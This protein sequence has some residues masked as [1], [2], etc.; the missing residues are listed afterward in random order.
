MVRLLDNNFI[1]IH[2]PK[3][4]GTASESGSDVFEVK[5]FD[6]NAYLAQS[7][8][9]YKQMAMASGF[10]R[11][12]EVG[13]VFRAEKSFTSKHATEF[14]GFDLE[15]SYIESYKDVMKMEEDMLTYA[16]TGLKEKYGNDATF[17]ILL[18]IGKLISL[19]KNEAV[20]DEERYQKEK[21]EVEKIL[22]EISGVFPETV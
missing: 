12:F 10:E 20:R 2:T 4:I 3:L 5:Y 9:F 14:T 16:L 18:T 15:F 13:P 22:H 6:R 11:I 19:W 1:E 8:Q 21:F 7:P 17:E